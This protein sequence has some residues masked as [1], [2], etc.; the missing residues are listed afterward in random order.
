VSI[1]VVGSVALDSIQ[2][3]FGRVK[4]AVGGSAVYFSAAASLYDQVNLVGVVGED[5]PQEQIAFLKDR[6]VD[7]S[8]LQVAPGKT[9]RWSGR[10]D[11]D[12]NMAETLDTQLNVFATF[13]PV[14]P[15]SYRD[16]EFV[17]L[18]NIDPDLQIEVLEQVRSPKLVALDTM[19]Y[20]INYKKEALT[21]A[22]SQADVILMNETEAR[23]YGNTFSLIRAARKITEL[24]PRALIVKKGEYGAGMFAEGDDP[25]SSYFFAPA[26]PL[27]KIKDPT[28]AGDSFAGGFM[29]YLA[30]NGH[31]TLGAIKRGIVHGSVVASFTVEG[32]SLERLRD[33]TWD[34]I[35]SRYEEFK[36]FT[37]FDRF[38][39]DT[40]P[41]QAVWEGLAHRV[42]NNGAQARVSRRL[43]AQEPEAGRVG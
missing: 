17:F 33:L 5:F 31:F 34:E 39:D 9:F 37:H 16:S 41:S 32:F 20:W 10:Y 1:L 4:D 13:H 8:G 11:Y 18:A 30:Q 2:T 27:E 42:W 21:H 40:R 28:G 35:R 26:Y 43:E 19:N 3:P 12:M 38:A 22:I 36:H 25:I 24:G 14:L 7:F 6:G 23:Q 15:E 29:G